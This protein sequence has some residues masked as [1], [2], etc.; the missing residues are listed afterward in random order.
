MN[1]TFWGTRGSIANGSSS[2]VLYGGNTSCVE[3]RTKA[4]TLIVLDC[5]T[6]GFSLGQTIIS[7]SSYPNRGHLLISHTHWDHIQGIPFFAPLFESNQHWTI[8][9]PSGLH[10]SLQETLAGQMNYTY[11][12]ITL[13]DMGANIEY[14]ELVEGVLKIDDVRIIT[15]FLNHPALTLGY[16]L[17]A[18]G[19]TLV[20]ACDHEQVSKK[21]V[22]EEE[23]LVNQESAHIEFLRDADLVIHD[24]Q[25]TAKDYQEK[26]GWGH[27]TA[28]FAVAA[29]LKGGVR[30][31]ALTHHDPASN[32]KKIS[33]LVGEL[34][35]ELKIK[36]HKLDVVAAAEGLTLDIEPVEDKKAQSHGAGFPAEAGD[37]TAIRE[38]T[39]FLGTL[40]PD[41]DKLIRQAA[42]AENIPI[43]TVS[44]SGKAT[45]SF[46]SQAPSLIIVDARTPVEELHEI[47]RIV[48]PWMRADQPEIPIVVITYGENEK[49]QLDEEITD[50]ATD[51]MTWP[52]SE[53]Y[54]RTKLRAWVLRANCRWIRAKL[55]PNEDERIATLK[56]LNILRTE[57]EERFDRITRLAATAMDVPIVLVSLVDEE[58]QWFKSCVGLDVR[59]TSREVAFCAH[60]ILEDDILEVQ[61]TLLDDRFADN[62][63]VTGEPKIRFYA[64]HPLKSPDGF[65]LGTLCLIDNKPRRLDSNHRQMLIDLAAMVETEI[66][67]S[68]AQ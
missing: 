43:Q 7:S 41:S 46:G 44:R 66:A 45:K 35:K 60:A 32:D 20:Y 9:A 56:G 15:R 61:D 47:H 19:A 1:V 31:L 25:Y 53:Q 52:F 14:R 63:L 55:P 26:A 10:Q 6:G 2:N 17:E 21:A 22:P 62:P 36:R 39:L 48:S 50:L 49:L 27:S 13:N 8:Y 24:A 5:G 29:S 67:A 28:E 40:Q 34:R 30:Q 54:A 64:G 11:S 65:A 58:T 18:D 33:D 42:N 23:E 59:E 38:H 4:G 12:P 51:W 16:R 68:A 3:V 37:Q 57:P